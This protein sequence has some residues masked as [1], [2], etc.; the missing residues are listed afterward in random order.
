MLSLP[1]TGA[2]KKKKVAVISQSNP[3]IISLNVSMKE[4][5]F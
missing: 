2:A 1:K 3:D 5:S 4:L